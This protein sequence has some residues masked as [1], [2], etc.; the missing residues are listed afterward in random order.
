MRVLSSGLVVALGALMAAPGPADAALELTVAPASVAV[1]PSTPAGVVVVGKNTGD[2]PLRQVELVA[3]Y[4]GDTRID[5]TAKPGARDL[6][7]HQTRRWRLTITA[8]ATLTSA[9]MVT[10]LASHR[11]GGST[12]AGSSVATVEVKPPP[13]LDA[14]SL[15]SVHAAPETLE[16]LPGRT[17]ATRAELSIENLSSAPLRVMKVHVDAPEKVHYDAHRQRPTVAPGET[18]RLK[19]DVTAKDDAHAGKTSAVIAL[20]FASGK[21]A[22]EFEL[23]VAQPVEIQPPIPDALLVALGVPGLVLLPGFLV[24]VVAAGLWNLRVLRLAWDTEDFP[25][26][27]P[28]PEFWVLAVTI[29]IPLVLIAS[30]AGLDPR[31]TQPT[32][33]VLAVW[34]GSV[35]LGVVAYA[36][37]AGIRK[38]RKSARRPTTKDDPIVTLERLHRRDLTIMR[39]RYAKGTG[40]STAYLYLLDPFDEAAEAAWLAPGIRYSTTDNA[41]DQQLTR[42]IDGDHNAKTIAKL[43]A[44]VTCEWAK[45]DAYE[46]PVHVSLAGLRRLP[47]EAI[48]QRK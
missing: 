1:S 21:P 12:R 35:V 47:A 20:S 13:A 14:A 42:E 48:V 4:S 27:F 38:A 26:T 23:A 16:V 39:E 22:T 18:A 24:L 43:L 29:S 25:F 45:A 30:A 40:E 41:L 36:A 8:S 33:V 17:T 15:V 46:G 32:T 28:A 11:G 9:G 7:P 19:L 31:E 2:D 37:V 44:G 10:V 6:A 3:L 5:A 34:G